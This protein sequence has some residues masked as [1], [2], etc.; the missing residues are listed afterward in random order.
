MKI[1]ITFLFL[2]LLSISCGR[3]NEQGSKV[4]SSVSRFKSG[5]VWTFRSLPDESPTA[6]L[7]VVQVDFDPTEGLIIYVWLKGVKQKVHSTYNFLAFSEAALNQSVINLVRTNAPLEGK[8]FEVFQDVYRSAQEGVK[9][10]E[11]D[12][13]FKKNIAEVLENL[14]KTAQ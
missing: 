5:Q 3:M 2:C 7:W 10:G 1:L 12:K 6:T 9:R 11:L 14:R 13:C 4:S 8:D